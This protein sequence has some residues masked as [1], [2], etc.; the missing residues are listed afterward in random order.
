[1]QTGYKQH[2]NL[3]CLVKCGFHLLCHVRQKKK[4][5]RIDRQNEINTLFIAPFNIRIHNC[6]PVQR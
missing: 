2:N 3:L 4:K 5:N 6:D 1:M